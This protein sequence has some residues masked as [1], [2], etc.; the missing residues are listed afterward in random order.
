[1]P[2]RTLGVT[3]RVFPHFEPG[4]DI[5][6][7]LGEG[8]HGGAD[9]LLLENLFAETGERDPLQRRADFRAGGWSVMTGICANRS[10]E[11][12]KPVAIDELIHN[13]PLPDHVT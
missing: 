11:L 12:G 2:A 13:L 4:Y 8:G 6:V 1:M 7:D 5:D 3:T 10:I 9:P